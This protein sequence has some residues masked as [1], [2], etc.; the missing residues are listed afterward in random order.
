[1]NDVLSYRK[2]LELGVDF[3]LITLLMNKDRFSV[4]QAME[5]IGEM[6]EDCYRQWYLALAGL[7]S[8]GEEVDREVMEFVEVCRAIAH[9][10]LYWR[11]EVYSSESMHLQI[12][13]LICPIAF[14]QVASWA[15]VATTSTKRG[16]CSF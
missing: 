6:T 12:S 14:K 5:R 10:N 9:R 1:V 8:Y 16:S 13:S 7:P 15:L 11:R 3:N 2:D 4:Q